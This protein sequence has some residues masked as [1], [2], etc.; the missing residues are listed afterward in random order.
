MRSTAATASGSP[1]YGPRRRHGFWRGAR[2]MRSSIRACTVM[3]RAPSRRGA[4]V[5]GR[6]AAARV[7]AAQALLKPT[8]RS[9]GEKPKRLRCAKAASLRSPRCF[10]RWAALLRPPQ[11]LPPK[12]RT[13]T[14][15]LRS[16]GSTPPPPTQQPRCKSSTLRCT[17]YTTRSGG[18]R[19][20]SARRLSRR[21]PIQR[22]KRNRRAP[23]QRT[24]LR[25]NFWQAALPVACTGAHW[26]VC[27]GW[28]AV[29]APQMSMVSPSSFQSHLNRGS[30]TP[31]R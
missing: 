19:S 13:S 21:M 28:L 30:P 14:T 10:T 1:R 18:C 6:A 29:S 27:A 23:L 22:W 9:G 15:P 20:S 11:N 16:L 4:R 8:D 2:T 17:R 7:A 3:A 12:L 25:L 31:A 5:P 24:P 26:T